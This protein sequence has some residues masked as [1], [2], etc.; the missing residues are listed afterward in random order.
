[1]TDPPTTTTPTTTTV[2]TPTPTTSTTT[3]ISTSSGDAFSSKSTDISGK[4]SGGDTNGEEGD[5][6]RTPVIL[7]PPTF[8]PFLTQKP[9]AELKAPDQVNCS[10]SAEVQKNG[11]KDG[12]KT[13]DGSANKVIED[14]RR[15][16]VSKGG[17]DTDHDQTGRP[18][19]SKNESEDGSAKGLWLYDEHGYMIGSHFVKLRN[20]TL[21]TNGSDAQMVTEDQASVVDTGLVPEEGLKNISHETRRP[22]PDDPNVELYFGDNL[23][24][25][26]GYWYL[27]E[28]LGYVWYRYISPGVFELDMETTNEV[29]GANQ[30]ALESPNREKIVSAP[31]P[32][33]GDATSPETNKSSE[34]YSENQDEKINRTSDD[35]ASPQSTT[36]VPSGY[37][38]LDEKGRYVWHR[39]IEA[40]VYQTIYP[41]TKTEAELA[42]TFREESQS[43]TEGIAAE[44]GLSATARSQTA[45]EGQ[46]VATEDGRNAGQTLTEVEFDFWRFVKGKRVSFQY[47]PP[48]DFDEN[49][50]ES[51]L[52]SQREF[53]GSVDVPSNMAVGDTSNS[54]GPGK[55]RRYSEEQ[56]R[57]W[58]SS[59]NLKSGSTSTEE[60]FLGRKD[61]DENGT[62]SVRLNNEKGRE[63]WQQLVNLTDEK[64]DPNK[65]PSEMKSRF[66]IIKD[67]LPEKQ[68]GNN[69]EK[70]TDHFHESYWFT[71]E[72]GRRFQVIHKYNVSDNDEAKKPLHGNADLDAMDNHFPV[73]KIDATNVRLAHEEKEEHGMH[74]AEGDGAL[75][76]EK[77]GSEYWIRVLSSSKDIPR[78]PYVQ[79]PRPGP[80]AP[81]PRRI[82]P[83][84]LPPQA[85]RASKEREAVDQTKKTG[86]PNRK[87]A[88]G[89]GNGKPEIEKNTKQKGLPVSG[90]KKE[91]RKA[92]VKGWYFYTTSFS[93]KVFIERVN[94]FA[95]VISTLSQ[96]RL[97]EVERSQLTEPQLSSLT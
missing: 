13:E 23:K 24:G 18:G 63:L 78:K 28:R 40:G 17:A 90:K 8:L 4:L 64:Q 1:M 76:Y 36:Q 62:M 50:E 34:W 75:E 97:T 31:S 89:Q 35:A 73:G 84:P 6:L 91:N 3:P 65:F 27:D 52:A 71:D 88:K 69:S 85:L 81:P 25:G 42:T 29:H 39:Y 67:K 66:G 74:F 83:K 15:P 79:Q 5:T 44:G 58:H 21:D 43:S 60:I 32:L 37:W 56:R 7:Q 30:A 53:S 86:N 87:Q 41:V 26:G 49:D 80:F 82:T 59:N 2:T 46:S 57:V 70:I 20:R 61:I 38:G 33:S 51:R 47:V 68:E 10:Q 11:T 96:N 92:S 95:I 77:Y 45:Y 55:D 14:P 12:E 19:L 93:Y 48:N 22:E 72:T 9:L 94:L 16:C 54:D